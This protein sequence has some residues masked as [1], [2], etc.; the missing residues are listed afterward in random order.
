MMCDMESAGSGAPSDNVAAKEGSGDTS[1]TPTHSPSVCSLL[2]KTCFA[3][4]CACTAGTQL[5]RCGQNLLR[6]VEALEHLRILTRVV[7]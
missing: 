5:L 1:E 2:L 3:S 6:K 4:F 7:E